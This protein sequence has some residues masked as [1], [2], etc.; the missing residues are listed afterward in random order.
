M[1]HENVQCKSYGSEGTQASVLNVNWQVFICGP[2]DTRNMN[3]V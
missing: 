1:M 3:S 2:G